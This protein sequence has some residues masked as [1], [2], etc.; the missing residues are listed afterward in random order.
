MY[1][2]FD[3][4]FFAFHTL[5]TLFNLLGWCFK[6]TRRINLFTL[7]LTAGSWFVLGIWYGWGYCLCT[8]LHWMVRNELGYHDQSHSYIH[9]LILKMTGADLNQRFVE[10]STLAGFIISLIMSVWLNLRDRKRRKSSRR[11]EIGSRY[12]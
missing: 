10:L 11:A 9:F 3:Y 8:D 1:Q 7:L 6:K 4:F 12:L 2:F 5:F